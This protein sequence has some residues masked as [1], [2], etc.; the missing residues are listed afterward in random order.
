MNHEISN[1]CNCISD[2]FNFFITF[3]FTFAL[4][5][6]DRLNEVIWQKIIGNNVIYKIALY[7]LS[8]LFLINRKICFVADKGNIL[9]NDDDNDDNA[10]KIILKSISIRIMLKYVQYDY[11]DDDT[12][13]II[14]CIITKVIIVMLSK[15]MLKIICIILEPIF[16]T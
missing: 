5:V 13:I 6:P 16:M 2:A 10:N 3:D 1:W 14:K 15:H 11:R 4:N 9:D 7:S 12:L 8:R